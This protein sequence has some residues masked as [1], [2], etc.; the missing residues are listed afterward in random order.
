MEKALNNGWNS[1]L[2]L[3]R[4]LAW[5]GIGVITFFYLLPIAGLILESHYE[6]L[7]SVARFSAVVGFF[8]VVGAWQVVSMRE[9][10]RLVEF[11]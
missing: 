4:F 8:I 11:N 2:K 3:F 9:R 6:T 7:S 10:R 5:Y 1:F